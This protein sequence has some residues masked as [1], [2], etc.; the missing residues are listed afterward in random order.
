VQRYEIGRGDPLDVIGAAPGDPGVGDADE[1]EA[2]LRRLGDRGLRGV[3]EGQHA[4]VVAA[5]VE[6]RDLGLADDA[7]RAARL[8]EAPVLG[9]GEDLRQARILV[10]AERRIEAMVGNDARLL[11]VV[12]DAPERLFGQRPRLRHRQMHP[13]LRHR[14]LAPLLPPLYDMPSPACGRGVG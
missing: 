7:H 11:R 12:A 5:V 8:A 14:A 9:E 6:R 1:R 10:A 3:V 13:L 4:D 2:T